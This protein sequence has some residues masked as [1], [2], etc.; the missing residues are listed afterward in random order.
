[1]YDVI[2]VGSATIDAFAKI[3]RKLIHKKSYCLPMN[4]KVLINN[5]EI[6][7][8]GGGTNV[9]YGISK[10]G[11]KTAVITKIGCRDNSQRILRKLSEEKV[12]FLVGCAKKGRTPFSVIVDAKGKDRSILTFKGSADELNYDEID[13]SRLK[14]KWFYFCSMTGKSYKTL[15]K[16]AYVAEKKKINI[17]FNPSSY[18]IKNYNLKPILKRTNVLIFNKDEAM[19]LTKMN[20]KDIKK[21]MQAI[22]KMGPDGIVVTD[23]SK[24]IYAYD[25][26]MVYTWIPKKSAR[27]VETTGAGDAFG[28]G[29]LAGLIKT[30]NFRKALKLGNMNAE[31]CISKTGAKEGLLTWKD[32]KNKL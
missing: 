17:L 7:T 31:G 9:A 4:G 21:M 8:G 20:G 25:G 28:S 26:D 29:F 22:Y 12:D 5:L 16:L 27:I 11:L 10:L 15:V 14:T 1:M 19:M 30:N 32:V 18:M 2:A 3:D 13:K 23:G 6:H 24:R